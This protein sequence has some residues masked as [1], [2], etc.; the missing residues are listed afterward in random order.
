MSD[1]YEKHCFVD[2]SEEEFDFEE[3]ELEAGDD[4]DNSCWTCRGTGEGMYDGAR[5]SS[6]RG[7][8]VN[9]KAR[10]EDY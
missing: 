6:C 9:R 1:Y 8:G 7:S 3:E 10:D 5:C 4:D 2:A